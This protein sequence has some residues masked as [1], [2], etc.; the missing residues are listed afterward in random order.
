VAKEEHDEEDGKE[1][2]ELNLIL[3][4]VLLVFIVNILLFLLVQG[5]LLGFEDERREETESAG[6]TKCVGD[7]GGFNEERF[8][9]EFLVLLLLL[10]L[11]LLDG[12]E[13]ALLICKVEGG[14]LYGG[15]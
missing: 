7:S 15:G 11:L 1:E 9:C 4:L 6:E 5:L 13:K 8:L 3:L 14:V 2:D 12:C 10:L